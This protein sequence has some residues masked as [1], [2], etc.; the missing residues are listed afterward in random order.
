MKQQSHPGEAGQIAASLL[1]FSLPL[2]L[3]GI[4]Q[5]LYNWVDAFVVGNIN[6]ELALAAV[7]ATSTVVNFYVTAVTGF[8]LGLSILFAQKFGSGDTG[9]IPRLL[10]TFSVVLGAVFAALAAAGSLMTTPILRLM[11]T[12]P[13]TMALAEA[14]L[15]IVLLGVPFL[16]V[17]NVYAAALRGIGDSRAPFLSILVS[18]AVNIVLDILLVA[19][20]GW[21]VAGA[22]AATV[23][24]Q[25]AMAG[26]LVFYGGR[27][28]TLLR[29]PRGGGVV[30][31]EVL[32]R[33]LR[34]GIPPMVQSSISSFGGLI[35]QNFMN[36][37]GTQTVAAIT[38][39]YRIDSIVI[40]P[41][42]NLASG[43]STMVA[44]S[45]GAG[46]ERRG[47]SIFKVGTGMMVVVALALTAL[48][49]PAGAPLISLF[50][51]EPAAV[52][53]GRIFFRQLA[54]FYVVYGLSNAV[55]GYL[56]GMG[57]VLY[58]S[59]TGVLSLLSRIIASYAMVGTLGRGTI[60]Y[61]EA[62]SWGVLLMLYLL[63]AV[64]RGRGT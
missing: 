60:A 3:S 53:I 14:Y 35:L 46:D 41:M 42:V 40:L 20:A 33:G 27:R 2:I 6:G 39:A 12:T 37:F 25:I 16:A 4:L 29:F 51:V 7:C 59:V 17:Y 62:L 64:W 10:S 31:R 43:I 61:A 23:A 34:F 55:R 15:R 1:K 50:G 30:D 11:N 9:P 13:D 21:G 58:S 54:V 24:S 57:D 44:Q 47:R 48:V 32:T 45:F 5:Q 52:E 56:E 38:T 63:R 18:S 8:T 26:F 19:A 36:G 22:A 28:Y 49:I